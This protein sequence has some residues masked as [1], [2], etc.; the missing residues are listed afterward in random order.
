MVVEVSGRETDSGNK[1][2]M[3]KHVCVHVMEDGK[4]RK[5]ECCS[6]SCGCAK[7][8]VRGD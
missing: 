1:R 5:G 2:G 4:E 8:A 7:K 3:T 6:P